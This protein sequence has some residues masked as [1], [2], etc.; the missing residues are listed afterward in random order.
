M[1]SIATISI[2]EETRPAYCKVRV[3]P[4]ESDW[5]RCIVHVGRIGNHG[6]WVCET[7]NG[8]VYEIPPDGVKFLDSAEKFGE[9]AWDKWEVR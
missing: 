6:T 9:I 2:T 8:I 1:S 3:K 4:N 7:D 5:V